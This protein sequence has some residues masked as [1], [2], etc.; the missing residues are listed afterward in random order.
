MQIGRNERLDR[1]NS[2]KA[3]ERERERE[4]EKKKEEKRTKRKEERSAKT[5]HNTH[6][7][8]EKGERERIKKER[9]CENVRMI[10]RREEKRNMQSN[11]NI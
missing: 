3:R 10:E 7:E 11:I 8:M 9:V 1:K 5:E 6:G 2:N 4:R